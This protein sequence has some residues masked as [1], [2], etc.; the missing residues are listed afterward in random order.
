MET[1]L[2]GLVFAAFVLAQFAA[3]IA[4]HAERKRGQRDVFDATRFD[5]L[6]RLIRN[7]GG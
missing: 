6:A 4:V 3:V 5:H 7:S 1:L 2:A